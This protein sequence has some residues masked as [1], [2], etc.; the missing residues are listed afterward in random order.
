[1]LTFYLCFNLTGETPKTNGIELWK[2]A[3]LISYPAMTN[4]LICFYGC[5]N[6]ANYNSIPTDWK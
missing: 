5:T 2:R 3:G 6:L 1:M 4:G